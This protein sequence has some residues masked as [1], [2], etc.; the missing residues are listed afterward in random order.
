VSTPVPAAAREEPTTTPAPDPAGGRAS[1]PTGADAARVGGRATDAWFGDLQA[2]VAAEAVRLGV[3]GA[4]VGV[5]HSEAELTA[6]F[7]VTSVDHPLPV[8]G[9][10]LFQ[11]GSIT[12]TYTATAV[13]RLVD[14]GRLDLD[15]PVRAYLPGLK[16]ADEAAAQALTVRHL[17]THTGGFVGDHVHDTA[18]GD[19]ALARFVD[20]MGGLDQLTPPGAEYS[21]S[22]AGFSLLGRVVEA[23]T[24]QTFESAA[25]RLVLA[26]LRLERTFFFPEEAMGHRFATGHHVEHR[27]ATVALPWSLPR[28]H[29]PAAGLIASAREQLRYARLQFGGLAT[30]GSRM[31]APGTIGAMRLGWVPSYPAVG[32][33]WFVGGGTVSHGGGTLGQR[34]FL[35]VDAGRGF[36]L[37]LLTNAAP[38]GAALIQ[39]TAR[40]VYER[41]Y[42]AG[43]PAPAVTPVSAGA[44]DG[45]VGRYTA[46]LGDVELTRDGEALVA[47]YTPRGGYPTKDAPPEPTPPPVRM[48]FFATE[49]LMGLDPPFEGYRAQVL[50]RGGEIAWLRW[51]DV[52][53][54]RRVR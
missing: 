2:F 10:T 30:D 38:A 32:L 41:V 29:W 22:N 23:V 42:G 50:R 39:A 20:G 52:R 13:L 43:P 40:W 45:Y 49:Q 15:D 21:Y 46:A 31:L 3:P 47:R 14:E 7:G 34:A 37:S 27:R 8:D 18:R 53:L 16:L 54:H 26:P 44:L 19:D 4:A 11:I 28:S 17:L 24:G 51:T 36:A 9:D 5:L 12:K 6:G 48:A 33:G 25:G 35:F 1:T